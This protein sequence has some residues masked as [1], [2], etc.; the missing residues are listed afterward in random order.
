MAVGAS[1]GVAVGA[2]VG[3]TVGTTG[4]VACTA[5]A[6]GLIALKQVV[7]KMIS[8]AP[9]RHSRKSFIVYLPFL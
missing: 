3:V 9:A 6:S 7:I 1:V 8:A 4:L 5:G 2:S